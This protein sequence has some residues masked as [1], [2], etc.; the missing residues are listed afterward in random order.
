MKDSEVKIGQSVL[1]D[2]ETKGTV[3]AFGFHPGGVQKADVVIQHPGHKSDGL[4]LSVLPERLTLSEEEQEKEEMRSYEDLQKRNEG[5]LWESSI[6]SLKEELGTSFVSVADRISSLESRVKDLELK[7]AK[8]A[9]AQ[10]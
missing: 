6:E 3:R 9:P 2:K 1:I 5:R 7:A 8:A 10:S 4:Q